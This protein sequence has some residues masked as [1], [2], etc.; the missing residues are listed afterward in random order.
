MTLIR[1]ATRIRRNVCYI[2]SKTS[3]ITGRTTCETTSSTAVSVYVRI[4]TSGLE[5][6]SGLKQP[7]SYCDQM[8]SQQLRP[9]E[10]PVSLRSVHE[11]IY[12]LRCDECYNFVQGKALHSHEKYFANEKKKRI[13]GVSEIGLTTTSCCP[14][15]GACFQRKIATLFRICQGHPPHAE[16]DR[17]GESPN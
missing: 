13:F 17:E 6:I 11:K 10:L 3:S 9:G 1:I 2:F 5:K 16:R 14:Q 8:R 7:S 12:E 15:V 4:S